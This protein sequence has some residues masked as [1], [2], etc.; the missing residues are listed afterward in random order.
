VRTLP[1]RLSPL[2]GESL[3]G[4]VARY[5]RTFVLQPGD[6]VRAFGLDGG[7]GSLMAAGRYGVSLSFSRAT[8]THHRRADRDFDLQYQQLL[9]YARDLQ[10][11]AGFANAN[12]TCGLTSKQATRPGPDAGS[13]YTSHGK[14]A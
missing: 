1:L 11:D 5:S 8:V 12:L 6:V 3:P 14:V 4:Y 9:D 7:A 2:D 13:N 10:R